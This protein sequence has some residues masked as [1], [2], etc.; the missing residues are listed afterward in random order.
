MGI[1]LRAN[2]YCKIKSRRKDRV[3]VE[4]KKRISFSHV[5]NSRFLFGF[6]TRYFVLNYQL[7]LN[8]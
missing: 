5:Y 2:Y 6:S 1:K 7:L 3:K 4:E 8:N